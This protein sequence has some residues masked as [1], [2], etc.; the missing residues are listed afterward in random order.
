MLVVFLLVGVAL[1]CAWVG[2]PLDHRLGS[3]WREADYA[4]I[5][6]NFLRE[7]ANILRPRIDWRGDTPGLVESE[8]PLLPWMASRGYRA[9]GYRVQVFRALS[10]ALSVGSLLL[11]ALMARRVLPPEGATFAVAA[12][13]VNPYLVRLGSGLQ[14]EPLLLVM[15]LLAVGAIWRWSRAPRFGTLLAASAAAAGAMLAK[16]PGAY[17]GLVF[18]HAVLRR[19][20][21]AAMRDARIYV[22]AA[23]ALGPPIAWSLWAR[24]FWI[25]HGNS[26]GVSNET[27][28]L[29]W[30][31]LV[32]PT[33]LVGNLRAELLGVW[34]PVGWVLGAAALRL[35]RARVEPLVAWYGAVVCFYLVAGNTSGDAWASYYHSASVAPAALLMGAGVSAGARRL[36]PAAFPSWARQRQRLLTAALASAT[37]V[38]L[39]AAAAESI[40]RRD[41]KPLEA[42]VYRC[43]TE[44]APAVPVDGRIVV[45][46]GTKVDELG[47]PVAWNAS[48]FFA[49]MDRRGFNYPMQDLSVE[50]LEGLRA[51]G[52]G[53]WIARQDEIDLLGAAP[54]PG[55]P[56]LM[57]CGSFSLVRLSPDD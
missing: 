28:L 10:A 16:L 36:L 51:R 27:H 24:Q 44:F 49:W 34:S 47:Q 43:A 42:E 7:D 3:G 48:L 35:P 22:A 57:R 31:A 33:F 45:R 8:F 13:A 4:Q 50:T 12:F 30:Q 11:F 38:L 21:L 15:T 29:S 26:L 1:R 2:R 40:H 41:T 6:R 37:L 53:Y 17:L 54:N 52:G 18:A 9:F 56:V 39:G 14:P 23:L 5:A 25:E 19:V 55:W 20:G 32:P 46:G